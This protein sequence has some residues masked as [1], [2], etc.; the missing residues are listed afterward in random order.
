MDY[1]GFAQM[2][3]GANLKPIKSGSAVNIY[4]PYQGANKMNPHA[5]LQGI[6]S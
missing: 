5:N 4:D 3:L 2:V 1:D 6:I